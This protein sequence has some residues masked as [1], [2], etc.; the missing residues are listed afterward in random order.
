MITIVGDLN[1]NILNT[2]GS[3]NDFLNTLQSLHFLPLIDKPTRFSTNLNQSP[4]L[5]DSIWCNRICTYTPGIISIDVTDHCP[6]FLFIP[7]PDKIDPN[8]K[9][10]F[11]FR[12]RND[13]LLSSFEA[14]IQ[15]FDWQ[16]LYSGDV[17]IFMHDFISKLDG[18]YSD[19][20]SLVKSQSC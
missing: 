13:E 12:L 3:T 7:L 14:K 16:T 19:H 11:C 8:D 5:L 20:F 4:S 17:S 10:E 9:I 6:I 1:V 2:N 18:M 15:E